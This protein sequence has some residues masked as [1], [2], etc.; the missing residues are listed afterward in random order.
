MVMQF[1]GCNCDSTAE[2]ETWEGALKVFLEGSVVCDQK[3]VSLHHEGTYHV[4]MS[5]GSNMELVRDANCQFSTEGDCISG[6]KNDL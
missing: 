4:R 2:R 5:F 1:E 6:G 3:C